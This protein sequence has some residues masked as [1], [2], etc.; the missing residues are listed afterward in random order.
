MLSTN[1]KV[2]ECQAPDAAMIQYLEKM[3]HSTVQ[4]P[5]DILVINAKQLQTKVKR[6]Q[7][8]SINW[9]NL[10]VTSANAAIEGEKES[11]A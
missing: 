5:K 6:M 1:W 11:L 3:V 4:I 10:F 8:T 2:E 7:L 9:W